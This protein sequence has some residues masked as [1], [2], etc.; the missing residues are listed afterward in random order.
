MVDE[1]QQYQ[2]IF[3]NNTNLPFVPKGTKRFCPFEK[4]AY[5][6]RD[7]APDASWVPPVVPAGYWRMTLESWRK[8][9][10]QAE[11]RVYLRITK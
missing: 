1:Y 7:L 2:H 6:I 11:F 4:G 9:E 8:G 3:I 10:L 5:W